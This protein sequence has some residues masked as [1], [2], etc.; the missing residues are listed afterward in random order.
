LDSHQLALVAVSSGRSV[1]VHAA[2][3]S[4]GFT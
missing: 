3:R 2:T 4:A 1:A